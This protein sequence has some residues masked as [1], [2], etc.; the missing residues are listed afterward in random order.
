ML[1]WEECVTLARLTSQEVEA[2]EESMPSQDFIN[3][4]MNPYLYSEP[5]KDRPGVQEFLRDDIEAAEAMGKFDMAA[6]MKLGLR[7]R[8]LEQGYAGD[9][10]QDDNLQHA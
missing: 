3:F 5:L 10:Q 2:L 9:L 7:Q 8:L 6:M 1:N 4:I